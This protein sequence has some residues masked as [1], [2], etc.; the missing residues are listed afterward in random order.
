MVDENN[1]KF[2]AVTSS[3][4]EKQL[5][6]SPKLR[7]LFDQLQLPLHKFQPRPDCP[8]EYDEQSAFINSDAKCNILLG[9]TG[10]VAG[11]TEV[12]DPVCGYPRRI[13]EI[14]GTWNV[15]SELD[16][17]SVVALAHKPHL[18]GITD[19]YLVRLSNGQKFIATLQHRAL[20]QFGYKYLSDFLEKHKTLTFPSVRENTEDGDLPEIG[21]LG[22]V[23]KIDSIE[24][25][26]KD[27]FYDFT[28]PGT[29]NYMLAGIFHHNSG[30]TIAAAVKTA[31][32]I[33]ETPP[34]RP[35][36]P[37]WVVGETYDMVCGVCWQE[38]L[39]NLIPA[40]NILNIDWYKSIRNWPFAVILR[41]PTNPDQPGWVLDFKSYSQGRERMQA[42]SIGGYWC[43]EE[44]P[45][46]VLIEVQGR[47]RDYD[48]P[49]WC[50]FTPIELKSPE[51]IDVY[52]EPP[53]GWKF[54][55]LNV[56][57]NDAL[58]EGWAERFL[59]NIP[60][61]MRETRR[62]GTFTHFSGQ[63]YKEWNQNIHLVDVAKPT[64][65]QR[66]A[67]PWLDP[68]LPDFGLPVDWYR[69]RSIDFGFNNPTAVLWL[70]KDN[71]GRF[72]VYD[73]H[74]ESQRTLEYHVKEIKMRAWDDKKKT[75]YRQTFADPAAAQERAQ[76]G[77]LGIPTMGAY[78]N[79]DIGIEI[80]RKHLMVKGD[81]RPSLYV[82]STRQDAKWQRCKNLIREIRAYHWSLSIGKGLREKSPKDVPVDKDDHTLDALRYCIATTARTEAFVP[83]KVAKRLKPWME[84]S[85]ARFLINMN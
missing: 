24:F 30:K 4:M 34:P 44:I 68:A 57:K 21:E 11:E 43:N 72:Y 40:G 38:K 7:G 37:F 66:E 1:D 54:F 81:G 45:L 10:C 33:L 14:D 46:H 41:N 17:R 65:K 69:Y 29:H 80:V 63:V 76:F 67:M 62:I 74:Y 9:G 12:Y 51:W 42:F 85:R 27:K 23:S 55:H 58:S 16:G 82:L 13:D 48:S 49:G 25:L 71:D 78:N 5:Q 31:K 6:A 39:S 75:I 83:Q 52:E 61:D 77:K 60:E 59:S 35:L 15:I 32:Y 53:K 56:E 18:K 73:E 84:G 50:D 26:R 3:E 28:V 19:L 22:E 8:E 36:C 47:C 79:R 64:E 70:A 2:G 20:T